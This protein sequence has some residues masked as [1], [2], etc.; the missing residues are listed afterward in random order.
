[1]KFNSTFNFDFGDEVRRFRID[2][3]MLCEVE[4]VL[5]ERLMSNENFWSNLGFT[6]L[7]A[8]AYSMLYAQDPRPTIE[9]VGS[10]MSEV[11]LGEFTAAFMEA[12]TRDFPKTESEP[13]NGKPH[14][15]TKG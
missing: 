5:G 2:M 9:Q 7:R 1:M 3:N 8:L 11:D 14:D 12:F 13:E 4:Q 15:P 10:W 6:Q